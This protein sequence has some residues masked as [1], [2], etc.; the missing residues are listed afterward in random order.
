MK[1][2][3]NVINQLKQQRGD[4]TSSFFMPEAWNTVQ[5][6]NFTR[7]SMRPGEIKVD[8]YDF[9]IFCLENIISQQ[10]WPMPGTNSR[11]FN[12]HSPDGNA[13]L[14]QSIIY[15]M[16][17]RM[18]TAWEHHRKGEICSGTFLKAI[19][20]LPYLKTFKVD[21]IY[22][23]PVFEYSNMYKKGELGSPY[24]IKNIYKLD[25]NL[26]DPLLGGNAPEMVETEFKAF[27]EAC[28]I[29]DIKVMV[30]FVFRTV[31][32]DNDLMADHPDW[33]YWIDLN[34][35]KTFAAPRID[36]EKNHAPLNDKTLKSLYTAP[37]IKDYL[38]SFRLPPSQTDPG[39]WRRI[40]GES[41]QKGANILELIE[42]E[43]RVTTAPGFSDVIN[44][45]QP[46]WT[47]VT[48]LKFYHDT[49]RKA[50]PYLNPEQPPYI[51]Q[52]GASLNLYHGEQI[53]EELW[54]YVANIIPFYQQNFGIDGARI[55]MGHALPVQLNRDIVTRAKNI[56]PHFILWSEEFDIAK[57]RAAKTDGFHFI[58]GFS[59]EIYKELDKP[60]F[61]QKL[62]ADT[63]AKSALPITAALETPD[64]PRLALACREKQK[65]VQLMMINCFIPN[66]VVF[67]NNGLEVMELQPMNL[68]LDNTEAGRFV[69]D[70][71]DPLYGKLAFFDNYCIHWLNKDQEW[72]RQ[73]LISILD[74]RRRYAELI[75]KPHNFIHSRTLTAKD[76]QL[77]FI[78]YYDRKM[79]DGLFVLVN[80]DV[81]AEAKVRLNLL[82]P[83]RVRKKRRL[84]NIIN[85]NGNRCNEQ[86]AMEQWQTL[87][88]GACLIGLLSE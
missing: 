67:I 49:H 82:L 52:D 30:D 24:A 37:N 85:K 68:G 84:V 74:L 13:P 22:L 39:L 86:W 31:S 55:D 80:R 8:P 76:N 53:N 59:W 57:A 25:R 29:L 33:F 66:A 10:Y 19:C 42:R 5:Y 2:L 23:L 58:S 70:E 51:L 34:I 63:L 88:P 79:N 83:R 61:N 54:E 46:P 1:N 36:M 77:T 21:I 20:L 72:M 60:D 48:Y 32:R 17:P 27:V 38:S 65:I 9:I 81:T 71:K 35:N 3:Q 87:A 43:F 28:H 14:A 26:H 47:D 41:K 4:S 6:P 12:P 64:T 40:V 73:L 45:P 75:A 78:G 16:F 44:D 62:F 69:L 18:F 11:A 7:D 15:S 50:K 56:N